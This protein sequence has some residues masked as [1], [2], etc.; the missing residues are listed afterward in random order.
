M[1]ERTHAVTPSRPSV[2]PRRINVVGGC[3]HVGLPLALALAARGHDVCIHDINEKAIRRIESGEMPFAEEGAEPLLRQML[4]EKRLR[5]DSNPASLSSAEFV[6]V[7]IG[8]PVDE[9]LNPMFITIK[10]LLDQL[11]PHFRDGQI[12]ILRSTIYPGISEKVQ[13]YFNNRGKRVQLAFCPERIAEGQAL[14]ELEALPQIVSA[15][16]PETLAQV[17]ELFRCLTDDI[18]EL[19]PLEAELAKLFTNVYRYIKF[20]IANQFFQI[21]NDYGLDFYRIRHAMTYRYPRAADFPGA[22]FAAGPCLFKDT[23]QL[24]AFNNNNFFL[25]HAAMLINE[26]LPNYIVRTLKEQVPL[27]SRRVGILG[28]AFK[29]NSDD[30]RESLSYKLKKILEIEAEQ[31][32]CSD[33]HVGGP[34]LVSASELIDRSDII[35]I[36]APHR[37]YANLDFKGKRVLDIW[38]FYQRG[39][40]IA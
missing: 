10:E 34:G 12:L 25:G 32:I 4:A 7:I 33:L 16:S 19:S 35:I 11:F 15:F 21:A 38:N 14:H 24:A 39:G 29:A 31:V 28:M 40:L 2:H 18:L 3:G 27:A 17:K 6:I 23:M 13:Q 30:K 36:G 5:L 26:G 37:E 9:H 22:G 8:T 20:S 1:T